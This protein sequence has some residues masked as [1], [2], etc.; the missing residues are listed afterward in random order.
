MIMI[1]IVGSIIVSAEYSYSQAPKLPPTNLGITNMQDGNPPPG[2]GFVLQQFIQLY[3]THR[4]KDDQG[5][6]VDQ[7]KISSMLSMTQLI[8]NSKQNVLG[9]TLGFNT[10]IPTVKISA[11]GSA[12]SLPA[13]NPGAL[14]DII[15][16]TSVQWSAKHLFQLRYSSRFE[17]DITL[18]TGAYDAK[19]QI[20]PGSHLVTIS[21]YYA[22]TLTPSDYFAISMRHIFTYN[23]NDIGTEIKRG[24]F[25][26][27][28]Y[29]FEYALS[30]N[31]R[32]ELAGYYLFQLLQ[33][34]NNGN[35][36]YYQDR[37]NITSTKERTFGYGPGFSFATS[38]GL[39]ME[40][41]SMWETKSRNRPEG[42]R[43]TLT[44]S[45]KLDK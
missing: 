15:I 16:G 38:S 23:F 29:A 11:A 40:L 33:D 43:T 10:L 39:F 4:Y 7:P 32:L 36:H 2:S 12:E 3:Q 26:N 41:K 18:P 5:N 6:I 31:L 35:S 37:L 24:A 28:N 20:N 45:Y 44:L 42:V 13:I 22:F 25:Y 19:Y 8:Y 21:P 34:S 1:A 9:G 30:K 14:G 17:A 27:A